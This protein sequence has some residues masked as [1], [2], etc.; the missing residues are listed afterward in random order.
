MAKN[1]AMKKN[2]TM[3]NNTAEARQG[4]TRDLFSCPFIAAPQVCSAPPRM[5][6]GMIHEA[7]MRYLQKT[8]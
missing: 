5:M 4:L 7:F 3:R 2:V 8:K 1:R 6:K